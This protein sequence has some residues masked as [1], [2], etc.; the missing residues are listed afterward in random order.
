MRPCK[1]QAL[2]RPCEF[3][4]SCLA[5]HAQWGGTPTVAPPSRGC[6]RGLYLCA[7]YGRPCASLLGP[8]TGLASLASAHAHLR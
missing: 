6:A 7:A 3:R 5:Y 4:P 8:A 2:E 1:H